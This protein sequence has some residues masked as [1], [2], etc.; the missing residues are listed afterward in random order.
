MTDAPGWT[1]LDPIA[2]RPRIAALVARAADYVRLETGRDPDE[3]FIEEN[4]SGP[5]MADIVAIDG[6]ERADGT[7][8]GLQC[9]CRGFYEPGDWYIGLLLLDPSERGRGIGRAA[10]DMVKARDGS[11]TV[12][13]TVLDANPAGRRFWEREGFRHL[14][15]VEPP[16]SG[17]HHTKHVLEWR[18][19]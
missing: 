14:K 1:S 16:A 13:I 2:D 9:A 10:V 6:Y 12:R 5:P 8:G 19:A 18:A 17:D 15:T 3:A 4:L 7:L 11:G